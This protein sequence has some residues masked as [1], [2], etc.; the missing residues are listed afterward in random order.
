LDLTAG[1][2][3]SLAV[4]LSAN[5]AQIEGRVEAD[6]QPAKGAAVTLVPVGT[7]RT[8]LFQ[9][10]W[11]DASGHFKF[12]GVAPGS[13]RLYAWESVDPNAVRYDPDYVRPF[14]SQGR[15]VRV[16]EGAHESITL[17]RIGKSANQ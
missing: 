3:C 16:A 1:V 10:A 12:E 14:E 8:D 9:S 7:K 17:K 13:Y 15:N 2:G 11:S 5:S 4:Y 6:A